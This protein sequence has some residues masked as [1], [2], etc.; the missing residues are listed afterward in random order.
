M[1]RRRV[2]LGQLGAAGDCVYATTV[3]RQIKADDPHCHLTWAIGSIFRHVIA[4]DPHV[5]DVWEIP[6]S[7][8]A[9]MAATWAAFEH[10]ARSR[11]AR[12]EFDD[13]YL[14]QI[15][16]GNYQNFDGTVRA[17]I[18]RGYPRP[19]TVPVTPVIRLSEEEISRVSDFARANRLGEGGPAVIFECAHGSGQ[20]SMTLDW[21]LA[22]ARSV[23]RQLP[24]V[25]IVM[26]SRAGQSPS[27]T[28]IV[29]GSVLT[30][31]EY[32]ALTHHASALI[33]CSS[34]L[35]WVCTSD[36]ARLLPT[37]QVLTHRVG[38][39]GAVVHDLEHWGLPSDH[40]IEMRDVD[41]ERA[42]ACAVDML[43]SGV[44]HARAAYHEPLNLTLGYYYTVMLPLLRRGK[45]ATVARS[46][47]NVIARYGLRRELL[48][49]LAREAGER[50]AKRV[51]FRS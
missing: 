13:V 40:V 20:S 1:R 8:R 30:F 22:V 6:L 23:I 15:D 39:C 38:M 28:S 4:H 41:A 27:D 49:D 2:L 42:A 48:V 36:A 18:F 21:A 11:K 33:G 32:A 46:M 35:T 19:I 16:P 17:S 9:A 44:A 24:N 29:D 34:G 25:K 43:S 51:P 31:R 3:A 14:T 47:R 12:G 10:E 7:S 26:S 5:D 37:L 45:L 50:A